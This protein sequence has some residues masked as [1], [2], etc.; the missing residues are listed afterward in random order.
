MRRR[1]LLLSTAL[2]AVVAAACVSTDIPTA[3]S[4]P[5][6]SV[7]TE[8]TEANASLTS[9]LGLANP[10]QVT[11]LQRTT[12]LANSVSTSATIGPLGGALALPSAGLL[13]VVPPLALSSKQT[14]T[15]TA[16]AGS[17]VEYEFAPH[18]LKFNLPLVVTQNLG[19]TQA[20]RNGLVN[21][22]SL[23]AG[24]FPDST[25]PTSITEQLNVNVD[26]LNSVATFT[27]WHFSGYILASGRE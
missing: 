25:K 11:P 4:G 3:P 17:N 15:V 23:F 14:I 22:L 6:G 21:P 13:V 20:S 9:L 2:V 5:A 24:Y 10:I 8:A 19:L 18:G 27:V 7:P 1:I 12:P 16:V 26:L